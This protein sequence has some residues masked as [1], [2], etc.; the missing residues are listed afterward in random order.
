MSGSTN[1]RSALAFGTVVWMRFLSI[2]ARD[3]AC[4]VRLRCGAERPILW[5]FFWCRMAVRFRVQDS[6]GVL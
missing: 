6:V 5:P 4:K 1:G 3:M 2:N